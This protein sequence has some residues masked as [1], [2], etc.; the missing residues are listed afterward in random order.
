MSFRNELNEKII[1][2]AWKDEAFKEKLLK[3]PKAALL[4]MNPNLPKELNIQVHEESPKTIHLVL[5]SDPAKSKL[6]DDELDSVVGAGGSD[7]YCDHNC[8]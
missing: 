7:S 3:D 6:S 1:E 5:P 4:Q 8:W 2:R